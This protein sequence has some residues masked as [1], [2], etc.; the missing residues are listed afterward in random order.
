M[1]IHYKNLCNVSGPRGRKTSDNI[2]EVTCKFCLDKIKKYELVAKSGFPKI[3]TFEV[4]AEGYYKNREDSNPGCHLMFRCP[5]CGKEN[6]HGGYYNEKGVA[7]GHRAS[8][9]Q[10]W[11]NGYN[12]KEV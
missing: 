11:P 9:C 2:D 12:I 1:K 5:V 8:H 6:V 3:P 10:C 7:D 4:K